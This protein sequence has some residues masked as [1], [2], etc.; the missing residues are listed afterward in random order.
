MHPE[1]MLC[2][3]VQYTD[4]PKAMATNLWLIIYVFY[5]I[6]DEQKSKVDQSGKTEQ[7]W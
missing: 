1:S 7:S 4:T 6:L 5:S 3:D 2:I